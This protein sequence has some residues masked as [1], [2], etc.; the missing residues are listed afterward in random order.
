MG[1]DDN[2][3]FMGMHFLGL[4]ALIYLLLL[5]FKPETTQKAMETSIDILKQILPLI[6]LIV[7]LM[8]VLN[9]FMKLKN[10]KKYVGDSSGSRG[11][12][13]AVSMGV[14]SH[15]PTYLWY[16][17]L[18]DLRKQ[19]MK[20]GLIAAFLYARAVKIPLLPLIAYYFGMTFVIVLTIYMIIASIIE[21]KIIELLG[22]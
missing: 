10:I 4:I 13:I 18:G 16:P 3:G 15:G 9:Y 2:N 11:W 17:L 22:G 5:I 1:E 7:L 12:M 19:G 6:P 20:D 21:G 14:L 8:W